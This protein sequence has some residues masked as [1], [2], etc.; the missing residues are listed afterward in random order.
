M[1]ATAGGSGYARGNMD[2]LRYVTALVVASVAASF[3]D[4]YFMGVL[5][6]DK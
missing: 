4:W 5:F 1:L 6:H 2:P 3:S